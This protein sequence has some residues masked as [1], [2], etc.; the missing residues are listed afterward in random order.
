MTS[1]VAR[2]SRNSGPSIRYWKRRW[3]GSS[4][5]IVSTMVAPVPTV[6]SRRRPSTVQSSMPGN[7]RW[8]SSGR[9]T[10]AH[11]SAAG[12]A[13]RTWWRTL[14]RIGG[15]LGVGVGGSPCEEPLERVGH[16]AG[17]RGAVE[18]VVAAVR[19]VGLERGDDVDGREPTRPRVAR[20]ELG[21][22]GGLDVARHD[23]ADPS[24]LVGDE[25]LERGAQTCDLVDV[26]HHLEQFDAVGDEAFDALGQWEL[27]R[28]G[29]G[30]ERGEP[31][32]LAGHRGA[33]EV[34][35]VVEVAEH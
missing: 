9:P 23:L 31:L 25:R 11:T 10:T 32:A 17:G 33:D 24:E 13:M 19:V 15:L 34:V 8:S 7:H 18:A 28:D 3:R 20:S 30:H 29:V 35:E 1:M 2:C 26:A 4:V 5:R 12:R 22:E 6:I 27:G 14:P 21:A 16:R